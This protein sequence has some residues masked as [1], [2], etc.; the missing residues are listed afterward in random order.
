[1]IVD[2][3]AVVAILIQEPDARIYADCLEQERP[4][5]ISAATLVEIGIVALRRGGEPLLSA[6]VRI[7][8]ESGIEVAPVTA[9]RARSAIAAYGS[10]GRG[11]GRPACLTF[12]DC[13][14]Y[15]LAKE[16]SE[17]LL[18]KGDDFAKTDVRSAL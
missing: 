4:L 10:F 15:A 14:S 2:T 17:P 18:Y 11:V 8:E 1:V 6:A 13:F 5:R 16:T 7:V 9:E 12:G 3:S